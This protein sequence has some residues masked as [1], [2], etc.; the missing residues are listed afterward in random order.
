[1]HA[2]VVA[3]EVERVR[4]SEL[5]WF[6]DSV[7]SNPSSCWF[8]EQVL[9]AASWCGSVKQQLLWQRECF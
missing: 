1:M 8:Q 6:L 3:S 4:G 2:F 7:V 9:W 5:W